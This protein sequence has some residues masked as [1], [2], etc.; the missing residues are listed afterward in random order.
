[1][2]FTKRVLA[3]LKHFNVLSSNGIWFII[4]LLKK[5]FKKNNIKSYIVWDIKIP[6]I[7]SINDLKNYFNDNNI[8]FEEGTWSIYLKEQNNLP[9]TIKNIFNFYPKS[10]GIKILKNIGNP[11]E[12]H[13]LDKTKTDG[14]LV[15]KF[16]HIVTGNLLNQVVT[17][18]YMS[19]KN[20]GPQVYDLCS[21]KLNSTNFPCFIVENIEKNIA[22]EI[23][24]KKFITMLKKL[25]DESLLQ[26]NLLDWEKRVDFNYD[27]NSK[28]NNN[29]L[30]TKD[31]N[32]R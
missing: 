2:K 1:M 32:Y 23:Q 3:Y 4:F 18:N 19:L 5:K 21:I 9:E 25:L 22:D 16:R 6:N 29:L 30:I 10:S 27:I 14:S 15:K 26:I 12:T 20:I 11:N 28:L 24:S 7:S 31:G 8:N 13:Y 17:A